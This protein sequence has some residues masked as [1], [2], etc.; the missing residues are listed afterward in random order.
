M[1]TPVKV[2]SIDDVLRR[3]ARHWSIDGLS[4]IFVGLLVSAWGL[5]VTAQQL[6]PSRATTLFAALVPS[7]TG[8]ALAI[9]HGRLQ[10]GIE[11]LK[12]RWTYPRVG[13][14]RLPEP[15]PARRRAAGLVGMVV[16]AVV[17]AAVTRHGA[18]W[19]PMLMGHAFALA[20]VLLWAS[21]GIPRLLVY[22][23]VALAAGIL[24]QWRFP[25]GLG[26]AVVMCAAGLAWLTGGAI[27]FVRLLERPVLPEDQA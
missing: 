12:R 20:G 1:A 26:A 16:A 18:L 3:P 15:S 6:W 2:E 5:A 10:R 9:F 7:I 23:L 14:V 25:A 13:Y 24:A 8:L 27:V 22:A 11:V 4:E 19:L 21:L 17:A